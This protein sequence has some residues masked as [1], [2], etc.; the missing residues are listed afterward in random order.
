VLPTPAKTAQERAD[1]LSTPVAY[2]GT[3]RI[4][5]DRWITSVDVAWNPG[6]VGTEQTRFFKVDG[7]RLQVVTPWRI[8]PNWPEKG[9]DGRTGLGPRPRIGAGA[10]RRAA[11]SPACGDRDDRAA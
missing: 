8:V 11:S 10:R 2:T 4:E 6:R 5:G 3:Y 7:D 1:L 9:R